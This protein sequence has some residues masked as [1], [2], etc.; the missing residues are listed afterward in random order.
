MK[1]VAFYLLFC[2][3]LCS[4][5]TTSKIEY[6][7]KYVDGYVSQMQHDTI[8][9]RTTDSVYLEVIQR[10]DTIYNTKY[11]EVIRWRDRI[12]ERIDTVYRDSTIVKIAEKVKE[13]KYVPK[14]YR[15]SLYISII[16]LIFATIK[17]AIW[18]KTRSII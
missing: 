9:E 12:V 15:I 8:R 2:L 5:K 11:K 17:V 10:G 14:I 18:L 13:V 16:L 4:C 3:A 6:W 7:D 1:K